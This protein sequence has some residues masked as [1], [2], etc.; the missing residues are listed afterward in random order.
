[1]RGN[2]K[3]D[4]NSLM[5]LV[6]TIGICLI[7]SLYCIGLKKIASQLEFVSIPQKI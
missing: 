3:G 5:P 1:M 4:F 6:A 7:L 2:E